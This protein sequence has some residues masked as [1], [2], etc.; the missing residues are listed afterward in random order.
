[1]TTH[2]QG[3]GGERFLRDAATILAYLEDLARTGTEAELLAEGHGSVAVRVEEAR[4]A[5]PGFRVRPLP[6]GLG[7]GAAASLLFTLDGVRLLAPVTLL[8]GGA[9]GGW[10]SLPE[11][12][13]FADRRTR[14]RVHFG[15]REKATVT[16]LEGFLGAR[17]VTGPLLNLSLEGIRMR[18]DRAI[19][20]RGK[21]PLALGAATFPPGSRFPI[22]RIDQLPYSPVLVC[23]GVLAHVSHGADGIQMGIRFVDLGDMEAQAIRQV[24]GRRLHKFNAGFPARGRREA[25]E[26]ALVDVQ[27]GEAPEDPPR[28]SRKDGRRILVALTDDL[29]RTILASSLRADGYRKV[30]EARSAAEAL[31]HLK[32]FPMDVV[33]L[34]ETVGT[35]PAADFLARI[36]RRGGD[37]TPAL[38]LASQVDVRTLALARTAQIE[39][40][41]PLGGDYGDGFRDIL[42]GLLDT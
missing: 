2:D 26:K 13:G 17:G 20:V 16:A 5:P 29:D 34:G 22:L 3:Q 30:H 11:A 35:L 18:V 6:A 9:G 37:H 32:V 27:R 24:L 28:D 36:R 23:S 7:P 12:V 40:V 25:P 19:T 31:D 14:M 8:E 42:A 41:L 4:E 39:H 38:L 33:I 1:M 15:P 21:A 10:F